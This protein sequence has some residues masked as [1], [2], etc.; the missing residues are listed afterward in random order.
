M[1]PWAHIICLPPES[2]E[3]REGDRAA[4]APSLGVTSGKTQAHLDNPIIYASGS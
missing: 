2:V 3:P 4:T 1:L